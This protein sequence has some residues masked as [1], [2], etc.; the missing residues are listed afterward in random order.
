MLTLSVRSHQAVSL[1]AAV[2]QACEMCGSAADA[3]NMLLCDTC[4]NGCHL[5]CASPQL[6]AVPEG[7]WF[8]AQCVKTRGARHIRIS[9]LKGRWGV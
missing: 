8:C 7:D 1:E 2:D 4:D 3:A 5:Y 9:V 6:A